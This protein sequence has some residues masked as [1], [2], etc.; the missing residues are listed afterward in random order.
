MK[1]E[2]KKAIKYIHVLKSQAGI[3]D[4][5]YRTILNARFNKESS[6]EL[7]E[8]QASVLIKILKGL[9]A[10]DKGTGKQVA[11]FNILFKRVFGDNKDKKE[12]IKEQTGRNV[13]IYS[14]TKKEYNNLI[15]ALQKIEE[16]QKK[17]E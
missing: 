16:W 6:K 3:S 1:L 7:T 17:D 8:A 14:L 11:K 4:E 5:N 12:F 2:K 9:V 10:E 13:S 15:T